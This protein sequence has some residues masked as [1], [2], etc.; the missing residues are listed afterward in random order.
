MRKLLFSSLCILAAAAVCSGC[1]TPSKAPDD[2]ACVP[3]GRLPYIHPGYAETVIP[4]NIAPLNFCID[5]PGQ[6]YQVTISGAKGEPIEVGSASNAIRIPISA[7]KSLLAENR[8]EEIRIEIRVQDEG[9][10][11]HR[12]E[13]FTNRVANEDIDE[14]LMYRIM[15]PWYIK[16]DTMAIHQRNVTNFDE[17][18][19]I[20]TKVLGRGCVN[21]HA[22]VQNRP[23][24]MTLHFR[25]PF[26]M[27]LAQEGEVTPIDTRTAFNKAP[28]AYP[29]WH[30]NGR[31]A[32]Y[33][34]NKI[35]QVFH[36]FGETRDVVDFSSNVLLYDIA[37]NEV[38]TIPALSDPERLETFPAWSPDGKYLYFCS[39][40][41]LPTE[42]YKRYKEVRYDLMRLPFDPESNTWGELEVVVRAG[43]IGRSMSMPRVS[44][45]GRFVLLCMSEYGTFPIFLPR[46]GPVHAGSGD[47]GV[48]A[49]CL[50]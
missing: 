19:I 25:Y 31:L 45:D 15:E 44:P 7:W 23:D 8:G 40:P 10:Q 12:F 42:N 14:Y 48:R 20:D 30:P 4:P 32:A 24:P 22:F 5:E 13:P 16:F 39:A 35:L 17:V 18:P 2:A 26:V 9:G 11:W 43:D 50:Q 1:G 38:T 6:S 47:D 29:A 33:S 46:S 27:L 21:C 37:A 3:A 28:F 49:A 36:T 34:V 41:S